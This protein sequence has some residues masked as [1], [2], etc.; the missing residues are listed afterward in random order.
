M[1]YPISLSLPAPGVGFAVAN[2]E[3][4]HQALSEQG[5]L[6]AYVGTDKQEADPGESDGEG[7]TV[8]SLRAQLDA[9][10]IAYDKRLGVARLLDLLPKG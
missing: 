4:E 2:D 6:P 10:G 1:T 3:A 5:Y 8:E 9:A 7:H